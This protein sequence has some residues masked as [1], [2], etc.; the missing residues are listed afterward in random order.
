MYSPI[1]FLFIKI[2][3]LVL[4]IRNKMKK[5][6]D[7]YFRFFTK[8]SHIYTGDCM[9]V[10]P[11]NSELIKYKN[12]GISFENKRILSGFNLSIK[13]KQ[14]ILLRGKS[15]AG[16]TTLLKMVLG[17]TKP[18]EGTLYFQTRILDSKTCWE[19][20]KKIAYVMQDTDLGEGKVRKLLNEVFSYRTK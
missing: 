8:I 12:I 7:I 2:F 20:R 16:K 15:G 3:R 19:A 10:E 11:L 17:F 13:K 4:R 1:L 9:S 14:K 18:A 6:G 5:K